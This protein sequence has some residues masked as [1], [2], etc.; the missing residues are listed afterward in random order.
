MTGDSS[1]TPRLSVVM[2]SLNQA[3][4]LADA[5]RSV[6]AQPVD[7]LELVVQD[8]GSTDGSQALLASLAAEF[9]NRLR[10]RSEADEGPAD[11]IHRAILVARAP[12]IGWLNS[13]DLYTPGAA[14]RAL[15]QLDAH[16]DIAMV[17]GH[18][19][20]VDA[21]GHPLGSYPTQAPPVALEAFLDGCFICQPTVYFRRD[22][23]MACGGIDSELR[24]SFDFELWI[25]MFRAHPQGIGFVEALQA[26]SRLHE[27]SI[28]LRQRER[29]ALEGLALL[30]RHFGA[31]PAHW[32][33]AHFDELAERHP[34]HDEPMRLADAMGRVLQ[35]A[36]PFLDATDVDLAQRRIAGDHRVTLSDPYLGL[37]M[38]PDG[39]FGP[40]SEIR[41][42]QPPAP[43]RRI[44][45]AL[46]LPPHAA[47]T[48]KLRLTHPDGHED[49]FDIA[50]P[51]RA[52]FG[53]QIVER[54][55]VEQLRYRLQCEPCFV[56]AL[57]EPGSGDQRR[58]ACRVEAVDAL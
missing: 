24:A 48:L 7:D 33:L 14:A 27:G 15:A 39:W 19:E 55:P 57:V 35:R 34:F 51:G 45:L 40:E 12:V 53:W 46:Q 36:T 25:R 28:T 56:P 23:Y 3:A 18:G 47:P 6:M 54:R 29:V 17:Y 31:A 58:L 26:R 13:D 44:R 42:W 38:H 21:Q 2:P 30:H 4:F 49:R 20:H 22:A 10:W 1:R 16:P 32:L 5:V 50:G 52:E 41:L 37:G 43:R 8:G 9:P 11:A